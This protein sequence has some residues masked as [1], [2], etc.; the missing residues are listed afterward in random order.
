MDVDT[1]D[2]VWIPMSDGVRLAA[3]LW[4]PHG[5]RAH[6]VP[7][8]FEFL[9]YRQ[10]DL[11]AASDSTLYPAWA[12]HGYA[13]ARVDLRGTGN[14][15]GILTDEYTPQEQEDAVQVIAWLAAQPWCN[16]R[17][18]MTGVS[19]GGF[20]ALQ[21]AAR[22]PPAL[23][24]V[25][26]VCAS[27]D[28][29][30]DDVHYRGGAVLA[31]D[32]LQWAVSMLTWNS[33]P[34]DPAVAGPDWRTAWQ[35][36]LAETPAFLEPWLA[37]QRRDAYWR[38]GSVCEN[39]AAITVPVYAVGG[40][41]DGYV[42]AVLRLMAGLSG[43]RKGLIGPWAHGWP[44]SGVPGPAI[45][46]LTES[47]RWWD[48][49]LKG[50]DTGIMQEPLLRV[51]LQTWTDPAPTHHVWP[52]RWV[53]EPRWPPVDAP[54]PQVLFGD[55]RTGTLAPDPSSPDAAVTYDGQALVGLEAGAWCADGGAGD[56]PPDQRGEDGKS[57]TFTSSPLAT[58][59]E[60]LGTVQ[61]ELQVAV[62]RPTA[63]LTARLLDVAPD[64]RSL[65]VTRE[66]LNLTH[67]HGHDV[68]EPMPV[69]A[70][71]VIAWALKPIAYR[72]EPGHRVRLAL[73]TVYWPWIWPAPEP[74]ALTV[75]GGASTRLIL[76]VRLARPEDAA[77]APFGDPQP[78][79]GL[80]VEVIA[81]RPTRRT[82]CWDLADEMVTM[83]FDWDVG[84][85]VRLPTLGVEYDGSNVTH[86]RIRPG[87]PLSAHVDTVQS[88]VL[89]RP[90]DMDVRID[91]EG[92]MTA[93]ATHFAVT[94][95]LD[96]YE[97]PRRVAARRWAL[98]VPRD[99]T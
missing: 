46:F 53:A 44:D 91:T 92:T 54:A 65:L 63:A 73:S 13:C 84:G 90:P 55:P 10:G 5:A 49:W 64:G 78:A 69:G 7:A 20:N 80:P 67:R 3:R 25:L 86:Y 30:A 43:P 51:W 75:Y 33:L 8:L 9:P 23:R 70:P 29:Y 41:A 14:S 1:I 47:L 6:P 79:E 17:V 28:R 38:Q 89:R 16:G 32:M 96:A 19:W 21:T 42:A 50:L 31:S 2:H 60:I 82:V 83:T 95:A 97:G 59:V 87:D 56:W 11:M 94:L 74:V 99:G 68:V 62:D 45:D 39:Y 88:A 81:R 26:S 66:T 22:R 37:H 85:H 77:L 72:F 61:V 48:Y 52:G 40:W 76:P 36:R 15:E 18:G 34:P 24:A 71:T 12:A 4:L 93:D 35:H 27:D 57:L 98:R 58:A